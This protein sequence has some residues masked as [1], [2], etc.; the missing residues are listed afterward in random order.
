MSFRK[1]PATFSLH[2][3][4]PKRTKIR[5]Q[6]QY[7][8]NVTGRQTASSAGTGTLTSPS[9]PLADPLRSELQ[10]RP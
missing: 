3:N 5:A 1:L 4:V 8:S 2:R 7:D 10:G 6:R 9:S